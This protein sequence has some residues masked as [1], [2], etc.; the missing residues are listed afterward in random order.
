MKRSLLILA[1]FFSLVVKSQV[2]WQFNCDT[3]ITW[4]YQEGDEFND[5]QINTDYWRYVLWS[6]SLY[7]NKEQQYYTDGENVNE[8]NG[9]VQILA[10]KENVFKKKKNNQ[11]DKELMKS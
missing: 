3:V 4:H 1:F 9:T 11:D 2:M 10:K 6:R 7:M 8:Q 5:E